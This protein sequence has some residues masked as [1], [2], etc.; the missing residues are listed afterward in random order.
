MKITVL[1]A[2]LLIALPAAAQHQA[3]P[4]VDP[5]QFKP[6][7]DRNDVVSWKILAQVELVKQKDRYVPQFAKD[8]AALDQKQ[9]KVQGFILPLQMGDKQSHFVLTAMPQTCAFCLPGGPESMVE[10]KSKTPVKYTFEPVVMTGKL[11]VLKDDPTGVFY[12]LTDA[13]PAK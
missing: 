6:L 9:V 11:S 12:R 7:P 2:G 8:I 1:V 5:S 3:P 10:V 13:V 4:G